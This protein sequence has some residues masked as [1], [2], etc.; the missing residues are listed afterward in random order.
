M[1]HLMEKIDI[2]EIDEKNQD[3]IINDFFTVKYLYFE[4]GKGLLAQTEQAMATIQVVEGRISFVFYGKEEKTC[5]MQKDTI[6]AFDARE[7][8]LI[9]A[10]ENSK[11]LITI[12]PIK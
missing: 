8:H 7:K 1:T 2:L 11:V 9:I 10:H 5:M 4:A 3:I 12:I 6:L